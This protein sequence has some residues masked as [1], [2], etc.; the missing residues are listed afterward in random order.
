MPSIQ[1]KHVPADVHAVLRR[2]AA[3][4]GQSLQ[5][6]LLVRL[7]E[8]ARQESVEEVL[9]RAGGRAGGSAGVRGASPALAD[10][11][12]DG[13]RARQRLMGET[14]AAPALV[15]L[16]VASVLRRAALG[17][18]LDERRSRQAL[19]DLSVLPVRRISHLPMLPRIWELRENS[20]VYDAAYVAL[21]EL[22]GT[23]MLTADS[24]LARAPGTRC[25]IELVR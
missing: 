3:A 8:E 12:P 2:R 1:I 22:L 18:R 21:A 15:D 10:D 25:D 5:E 17:G 4:A 7:T 23:A 6:Y 24:R 20:T 16:E 14:L 19:E 11:G 13:D 9:E